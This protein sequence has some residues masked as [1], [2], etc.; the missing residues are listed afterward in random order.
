MSDNKLKQRFDSVEQLTRK[1]W[2]AGLGAYGKGLDSVQ[3]RYEKVNHE[4][5]R[6]FDDLVKKGENL[7]TEAKQK[8]KE[9]TLVDERIDEVRRKLGLGSNEQDQKISELTQKIDAL[10]DAVA[11][12]S[13]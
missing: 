8:I 7:E 1:I 4:A 5:G 11:K 13:K 2:L 10:T 3:E 6:V 9:T 12:L